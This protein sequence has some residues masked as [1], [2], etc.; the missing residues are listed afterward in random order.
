MSIEILMP[1]LSPTMTEG[2]LTKWLITEGQ[3]VKAGDVIAEIETDKATMEVEA[4]DEGFVEKLLFKEGDVNIPVNKPIALISDQQNSQLK[5]TKQ[6]QESVEKQTIIEKKEVEQ[7]E[8]TPSKEDVALNHEHITMR[9]AI[10]DTMA[11]EMRKDN[12]VFILGEEVAEYQGAYKVTQGLLE[13][14][15]E[16][17]VI[18]TPIS[19]QGFTGLAVGAAFKGLTPIVEFMTFN[20]SMQAIDQII[21]SAAKTLYMSGGQINCPIVFRGPNGAAAQVAAQHS[22]DFSSWYAQVPG[23][24]VLAPSTPLNAKGLLRSAIRDP[25]PVI[26]LENE[27]LYGLKGEVSSD[28]NFTIPFGKANIAKEGSDTTIV[29]YSIMLQK[30]LEAAKIL[31]NEFD[32]DVEV[33]DLQSLRPLD[34]ETIINSVKKT[35]RIITVEESW[36]IASVGSEVV[37]I[38]QKNAFDYLDAPIIK[39]NSADVPMPYSSSLE[40]LYLPQVGDIVKAVKEVNYI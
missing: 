6:K 4:V 22:Q 32:L 34:S 15:G 24:K 18:D 23:L 2:N 20:F 39:V 3:E 17:R 25:N 10:R 16:K 31:K 30:V 1:A 12:K 27:I 9:E 19:E 8:N 35:N 7:T 28:V 33:I 11:E 37:N 36:P 38:V 26:F 5:D 13:E 40:K 21:N 29:T 14:F